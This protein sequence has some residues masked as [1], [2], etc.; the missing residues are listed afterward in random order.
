MGRFRAVEGSD[1]GFFKGKR[2][3][4]ESAKELEVV[5]SWPE[6][7]VRNVHSAQ[8]KSPML[9]QEVAEQLQQ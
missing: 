4:R 8:W 3:R 5:S 1:V 2:V 7:E 6:S 9:S